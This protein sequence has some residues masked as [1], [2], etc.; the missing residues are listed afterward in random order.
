MMADVASS[1]NG[2]VGTGRE[3]K[4]PEMEVAGTVKR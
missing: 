1:I 3:S 4:E 2:K